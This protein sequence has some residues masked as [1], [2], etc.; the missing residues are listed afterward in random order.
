MQSIASTGVEKLGCW[1]MLLL[2][3]ALYR[4]LDCKSAPL[5]FSP[6]RTLTLLPCA[7]TSGEEFVSL[8]MPPQRANPGTQA[9]S[10]EGDGIRIAYQEQVQCRKETGKA[11]QRVD[12]QVG[13]TI[14]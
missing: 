12:K 14:H 13:D 8:F 5:I 2:I 11:N 6:L 10:V 3:I 1:G 9:G 4:K 7:S